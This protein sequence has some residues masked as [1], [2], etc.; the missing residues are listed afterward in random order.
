[1]D[2]Q[3]NEKTLQ[4][5]EGVLIKIPKWD[6]FITFDVIGDMMR[7]NITQQAGQIFINRVS[8][9]FFKLNQGKK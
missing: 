8:E 9:P 4:D 6:V 3:Y 5:P 1:M 7:I 2:E